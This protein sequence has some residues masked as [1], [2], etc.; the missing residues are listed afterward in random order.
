M[1]KK[2]ETP[3]MAVIISDSVYT[4]DVIVNSNGGGK[5]SDFEELWGANATGLEL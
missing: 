3:S 1:N 2:Y 5:E 4:N